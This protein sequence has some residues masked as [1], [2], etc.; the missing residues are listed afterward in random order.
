MSEEQGLT[1]DTDIVWLHGADLHTKGRN[2]LAHL[3]DSG[4][5]TAWPPLRR[6]ANGVAWHP[7]PRW[8]AKDY[9]LAPVY[10]EPGGPR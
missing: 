6:D 2:A 10:D 9:A 8:F 5:L 1:L 3:H 7:V 4:M